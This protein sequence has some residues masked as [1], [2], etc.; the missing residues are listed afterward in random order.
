VEKKYADTSIRYGIFNMLLFFFCNG[1]LSV[2][3]IHKSRRTNGH[4][5]VCDKM[6]RNDTDSNKEACI[7]IAADQT[8]FSHSDR[9]GPASPLLNLAL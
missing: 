3:Y 5:F 6:K 9:D 4:R 7:N 1:V 2:T 8:V